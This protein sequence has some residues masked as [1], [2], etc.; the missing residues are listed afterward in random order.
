M[1]EAERVTVSMAI[2]R[3]FMMASRPEQP[4]D[5]DTYERCRRVVIELCDPDNTIRD[6]ARSMEHD[7]ARDRYRGAQGD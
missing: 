3:I 7:A 4:G 2:G 1:T 5:G 6:R